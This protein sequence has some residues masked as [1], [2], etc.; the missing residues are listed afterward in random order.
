MNGLLYVK[1]PEK[2]I[3]EER[4]HQYISLQKTIIKILETIGYQYK[5]IEYIVSDPSNPTYGY[6]MEFIHNEKNED[7]SD[8]IAYLQIPILDKNLAFIID[9]IRWIPV[10]QVADMPIFQKPVKNTTKN[11]L[12]VIIQNTYGLLIMDSNMAYYKINKS[13]WPTFLLLVAV[14]KS[15][16]DVLNRLGV[17][18]TYESE[19]LGYGINIPI[20]DETFINIQTDNDKLKHFFS[21]FI[22][23]TQ[24]LDQYE[25]AIL[26]Y[27]SVEETYDIL[28]ETWFSDSKNK[29]IIYVVNIVDNIM[30]PNGLFDKPFKIIDIIYYLLT[31]NY[32]MDTRDIN[33]ISKRRV[34]LSE[35]L[36]Y[37]LTQQ[38]KKNIIENTTNVFNNAILDVLA[39]DQRR[40]L[41]DSVNPLAEL[42][43]MSRIIYNGLGGISK[44]SSNPKLRNLHDSY[45]GVIDPI[46]TPTGDAIGICQHIVPETILHNGILQNIYIDEK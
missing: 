16:D 44:E 31:T 1:P 12:E 26:E 43:M 46:D 3:F 33:D 38:H 21:P 10:F 40:I 20:C 15:Y 30:V 22:T 19:K 18:Y 9:G 32:K 8:K 17:K 2:N 35:W 41:D 4:L 11:E 34:R 23:Q 39:T 6:I 25:E 27:T 24:I 5:N 37:K 7:G 36:L 45:Y 29:N 42:C 13:Y 14:E 28:L